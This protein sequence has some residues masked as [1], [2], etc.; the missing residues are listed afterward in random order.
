MDK[1]FIE[2]PKKFDKAKY[3]K[4]HYKQ[5][6]IEIKPEDYD[7]I[8]GYCKKNDISKAKFIVEAC[9]YY[10]DNHNENSDL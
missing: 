2:R 7:L 5:L 10:A 3:N 9:K 4:E 8:D 1:K 6:K